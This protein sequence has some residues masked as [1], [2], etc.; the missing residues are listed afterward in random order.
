MSSCH[1]QGISPLVQDFMSFRKASP[2]THFLPYFQE[3]TPQGQAILLCYFLCHIHQPCPC[4]EIQL[5]Y[6]SIQKT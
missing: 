3:A 2:Q 4:P 5:P 1:H 6:G